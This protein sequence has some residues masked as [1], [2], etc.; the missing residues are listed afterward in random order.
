MD[1]F[2]RATVIYF[3]LWMITRGLG[4]RE[5]AE[6]SAFDL[7]LLVIVGDLVQQGVTQDDRSITGA[8]IAVATIAAWLIV[9]SYLS[10]RS[11]KVN[12]VLGGLPVVV[13]RDGEPLPKLLA[14]ERLR[15]DDV[16][17]AARN[18]GIA[19]LADVRVG[20]LEPDGQFSF[21]LDGSRTDQ[22]RQPRRQV[23]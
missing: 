18:Q 6:M 11:K 15:L 2:I 14:H 8:V 4:K 13:I 1:I 19:D 10:F 12:D 5:L 23:D 16:A 17:E 7:V 20:I 22:Q 3:L 21:V 9:F